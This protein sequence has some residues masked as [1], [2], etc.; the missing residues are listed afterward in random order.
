MKKLISVLLM[1]V[2]VVSVFTACG[3]KKPGDD[4]KPEAPASG[5]SSNKDDDD[6]DGDTAA[7]KDGTYPA[8][9]SDFD[10]KSGWKDNVTVEVKDGKISSVEWNSTHKDGGKDKKT[11]SIDGDYGM[12]ANGKA[13][14]EWHEQ[15]E[16][17]EEFLVEKQDVD[18]IEVKDDKT[19]DSIA[20]VTMKVGGF[21]DMVK[22]ALSKAK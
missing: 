20:G 15:A 19:T 6:K 21:V 11:A 18:A 9:E 17:V 13:I 14:A 10:E 12:V 22:E 3:D 1:L 16:K 5:D 4:N 2:L 8:E 7:L